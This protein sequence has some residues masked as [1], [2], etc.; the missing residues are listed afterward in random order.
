MPELPLPRSNR[1]LAVVSLFVSLVALGLKYAAFAVSGSVAL[2]ADAIETIINVVAA[3]GG[4]WALSVAERPA[5]HNHT[6]GHYKAEYLSAV[7]EGALVVITAF[8][9]GREAVEGWLHPHTTLAPWGGLLLNGAATCVNLIWGLTMLRAGRARHSPALVAGGQ[10]VLSDVWTGVALVV[11]VALIPLLGWPQLD[12]V[13]AG[14]VA[15][16]VLRVGWEV[17]RD[18][19]AG[20]MDEAPDAQ[21]LGEIGAIITANGQ[22]AIQAHD[23]RTRIVGAMTFLDFHLVVPGSMNVKAAHDICDRIE[24]ALRV[25][26]GSTLVH[27]HI[28]PETC[29]KHDNSV[30]DIPPA[31]ASSASSG[32]SAEK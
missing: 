13:L 26:M 6:Y 29:A 19:I 17:M 31:G 11:G 16:N 27:I 30:L 20:L 12:A 7:A 24:H 8:V 9:I 32:S 21:T 14:L 23:I 2:H 15:L 25:H 4:L 28:E 22:G 18:S 5:D 10:H 3:A 1:G